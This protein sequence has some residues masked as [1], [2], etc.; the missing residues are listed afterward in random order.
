MLG[1]ENDVYQLCKAMVEIVF[2]PPMDL[3]TPPSQSFPSLRIQRST[4]DSILLAALN[5]CFDGAAFIDELIFLIRNGFW[6]CPYFLLD[7][8]WN[9]Q[10][11]TFPGI[12][13]ASGTVMH[14][15]FP[16]SLIN[17]ILKTTG[18]GEGLGGRRGWDRNSGVEATRDGPS[19]QDSTSGSARRS[20]ELIGKLI[21]ELNGRLSN[22]PGKWSC[23]DLIGRASSILQQCLHD[24]QR[25][26]L[27][28]RFLARMYS[29]FRSL[30]SVCETRAD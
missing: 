7:L 9:L 24:L 20:G 12:L 2:L 27:C 17:G 30:A 15:Q 18:R 14:W 26:W 29:A 3:P 23:R 10:I 8:I 1:K 19:G 6:R 5:V 22:R 4:K 11:F 25:D 21:S 16:S 28:I 13:E